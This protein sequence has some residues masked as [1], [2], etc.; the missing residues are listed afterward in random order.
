MTATCFGVNDQNDIYL[1]K[2]G[3]LVIVQDLEGTLQACAHSAKTRLGEMVL[4]VN[5]GLPDFE[6]IWVGI[7]NI[8]QYES[9]IRRAILNV[10]GVLDILSFVSEISNNNLSYSIVIRTIYGTGVVTSG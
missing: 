6:L 8:P 2:D 7:P 5:E 10:F 3:N 4:A 1:G 9:S